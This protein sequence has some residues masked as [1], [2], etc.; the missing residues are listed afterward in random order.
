MTT[1]ELHQRAPRPLDAGLKTD[2][3]A[4]LLGRPAIS[5][6]EALDRFIARKELV[7]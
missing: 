1:A 4:A 5:L 7:G 3:L 2:K 6:D